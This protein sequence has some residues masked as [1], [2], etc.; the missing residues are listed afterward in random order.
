MTFT[1][2]EIAMLLAGIRLFQDVPDEEIPSSIH[3]IASGRGAYKPMKWEGF[4][5]LAKKL[6]P[7]RKWQV[8]VNDD[9]IALAV[10]GSALRDAQ[11]KRDELAAIGPVRL[12]EVRGDNR[13]RVREQITEC[14]LCERFV[15]FADTYSPA[16]T[17]CEDC[18]EE[19]LAS[20]SYQ[21][22][23]PSCPDA[24]AMPYHDHPNDEASK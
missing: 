18:N 15:R 23:D 3:A 21:C 22:I 24:K 6:T 20:D 13:P 2:R 10:Y 16:E 19:V 9:G 7:A 5:A 4:E 11:R 8:I 17:I 14:A 1:K 12:V